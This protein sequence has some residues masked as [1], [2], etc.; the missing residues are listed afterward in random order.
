MYIGEAQ[1][2]LSLS[3]EN[4]LVLPHHV[5][6][7]ESDGFV[8][9]IMFFSIVLRTGWSLVVVGVE[10]LLVGRIIW[11]GIASITCMRHYHYHISIPLD[12][13]YLF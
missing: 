2:S 9:Y 13:L 6:L 8:S 12:P 4:W 3:K 10:I 1:V 7:V 5:D 11:I